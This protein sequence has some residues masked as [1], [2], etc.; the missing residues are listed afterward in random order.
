MPCGTFLSWREAS[1]TSLEYYFTSYP[2]HSLKR[3]KHIRKRSAALIDSSIPTIP[4]PFR[5]Y[6]LR[7]YP[8]GNFRFYFSRLHNDQYI[9]FFESLFLIGSVPDENIGE[10][11]EGL[12]IR[13]SILKD[14]DDKRV[15][16]YLK[17]SATHI[18]LLYSIRPRHFIFRLF[19]EETSWQILPSWIRWV[20]SGSYDRSG[21]GVICTRCIAC[22][23][24]LLVVTLVTSPFFSGHDPV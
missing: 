13:R 4:S 1:V 9:P 21:N 8:C 2:A 20:C 17:K 14:L 19:M 23:R 3:P 6:R 5:S 18:C 12:C 22:F 16:A 11:L 24:A 15:D 10:N 7:E